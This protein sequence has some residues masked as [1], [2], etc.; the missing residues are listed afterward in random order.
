MR[1]YPDGA[2]AVAAGAAIAAISRLTPMRFPRLQRALGDPHRDE[3]YLLT[4]AAVMSG[5]S[6]SYDGSEEQAGTC[7]P[8][9]IK[10]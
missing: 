7:S 3:A 4:L 2:P 6:G 8:H 1:Q 9:R 5:A 10:E